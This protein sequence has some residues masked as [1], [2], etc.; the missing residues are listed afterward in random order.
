MK[1][2]PSETCPPAAYDEVEGVRELC[3]EAIQSLVHMLEHG[4]FEE[5]WAFLDNIDKV[6]KAVEAASFMEALK[7]D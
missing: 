1:D 5:C 4:T 3:S 2:Q 7:D 6:F